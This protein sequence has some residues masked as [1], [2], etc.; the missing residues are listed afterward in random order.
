M[1]VRV[2]IADVLLGGGDIDSTTA[3]CPALDM[4]LWLITSISTAIG[5]IRLSAAG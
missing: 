1:D 5:R 3:L 4:G 2:G